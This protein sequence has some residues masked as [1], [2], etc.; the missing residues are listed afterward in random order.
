MKRYLITCEE[1]CPQ[2]KGRSLPYDT[3]ESKRSSCAECRGIGTVRKEVD[4]A[5]A[6]REEIKEL[7]TLLNLRK[8]ELD[9]KEK[10][11]LFAV[12]TGGIVR[13][14]FG[15]EDYLAAVEFL[16]AKIK[17]RAVGHEIQPLG[18][19]IRFEYPDEAKELVDNFEDMLP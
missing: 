1:T 4:L 3:E 15:P 13:K 10:I 12:H 9:N 19:Q 11:G 14:Y 6:A 8:S 16:I 17:E 18:I 7:D 5:E 2:C